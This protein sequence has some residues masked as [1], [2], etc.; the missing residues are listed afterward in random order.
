MVLE[1]WTI[2]QADQVNR[3]NGPETVCAGRG[4]TISGPGPVQA[5]AVSTHTQGQNRCRG[6]SARVCASNSYKVSTRRKK[7]P[8]FSRYRI[9]A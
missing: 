8:I 7:K 4:V 1:L 2:D 9:L 6:I 5:Y 3:I